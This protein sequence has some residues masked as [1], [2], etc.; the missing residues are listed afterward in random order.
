MRASWSRNQGTVNPASNHLNPLPGLC[1]SPQSPEEK[2]HVVKHHPKK[3]IHGQ[4][5]TCLALCLQP[6]AKTAG[7]NLSVTLARGPPYI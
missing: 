2:P 5:T 6:P 4:M 1:S 7:F 3:H